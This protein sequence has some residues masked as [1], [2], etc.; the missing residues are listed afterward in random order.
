MKRKFLLGVLLLATPARG[1]DEKFA[2]RGK[3]LTLHERGA[4]GGRPA[5][6][7]SGDGGW[8]HLAPQLAE[9]LAGA[10]FFV[11]GLDSKQYLSAF[12]SGQKTLT[13]DDVKAD[14]KALLEH[15]IQGS[16]HRPLLVGVSEGAGLLVLAG[17]DP[18]VQALAQ[19]VIA[20]GLGDKN[21]L[22]WRFRDSI[23]YITKGVP[24]EPTF[25]VL[26]IVDRV[27][28]LPLLVLQST[29]DEFV[30]PQELRAIFDKAREPK[31][32]RLIE[33]ADHRISDNQQELRKQVLLGIA[34]IDAQLQGRT[35]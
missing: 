3:E 18:A 22:G 31:R 5:L 33:A 17:G 9:Q 21:E 20:C 30:P 27:S 32:L 2:L 6:V 13:P 23:I 1:A 16:A 26:E 11:V 19:G 15:T 12:T 14:F 28:P 29:H 4:R 24:N 8:V 34:W 10:G 25:S 7:A 35:P